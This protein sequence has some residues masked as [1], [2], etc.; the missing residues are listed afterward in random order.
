MATIH[1]VAKKSGVS[2]TTV[3]RVI[4]N[5]PHVREETRQ[6]VLAVFR[7]MAYVPNANAGSLARKSTSTIAVLV[8]DI[9]NT[10]FT[11][12]VRGIE[13]KANESGLSVILGNTDEESVKEQTYI[14]KFLERRVDGLI[15][16]PVE[17]R[18]KNFKVIQKHELPLALV[19]R[20]VEGVDADFVGSDNYQGARMLVKYLVELGHRE[21]AIISGSKE[22]SVFR[23]RVEGFLSAMSEMQIPVK[24]EFI[25]YGHKPNKDVGLELTRRL[26]KLDS[27]PT[28]IFAANNSLSV[29][30]VLAL[31]QAGLSVPQDVSVACFDD[32]DA[33]SFNPFFTS[34]IQPAYMMG[35]VTA[36][37]LQKRIKDGR[38]SQVTRLLMQPEMVIRH[39]T[40]HPG[41]GKATV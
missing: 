21:I 29:G 28:A 7:E 5:H 18:K 33:N 35:Y 9:T 1:D 39:S 10:F 31:Q 2:V 41:S 17:S 15:V 12:L 4:N 22:I 6:R 16:V 3:S 38:E 19:D 14:H 36:E 24:P 34:V 13:D 30:T 26:I 40:T 20:H 25:L 23:E 32:N 27:R 8:P 37:L 11:T